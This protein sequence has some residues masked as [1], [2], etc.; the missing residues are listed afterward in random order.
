VSSFF[1]VNAPAAGTNEPWKKNATGQPFAGGV[2]SGT[3]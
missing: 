3:S 1:A 2:P